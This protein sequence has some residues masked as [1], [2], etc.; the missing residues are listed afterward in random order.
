MS[1]DKLVSVILVLVFILSSSNVF[2]LSSFTESDDL[3]LDDDEPRY[4]LNSSPNAP[5]DPI[6]EDGETGLNVTPEL[7]V[8]VTHPDG[9]EMDV[10]FYDNVTDTEIGYVE[11]VPSGERAKIL[12]EDLQPAT[13]HLW[14]VVVYHGEDTTS[15]GPWIFSTGNV[16]FVRITDDIDGDELSGGTVPKNY[17]ETGYLSAYDDIHGFIGNFQGEW[18]ASGDAYLL[19][20]PYNTKNTIDVGEEAGDVWFNVTYTDGDDEYYH[21]IKYTVLIED[22][23]YIRITE[24]PGGEPLEDKTVL[25][26]T[27]IRGYASAYDEISGYLYTVDGDWSAEGADSRLLEGT[28]DES[29][30]IDVGSVGGT[31]W[32]NLSYEEHDHSVRLD[33]LHPTVDQI[34]ITDI[35]DGSP[36]IGGQVP[37]GFETWGN[38]S[39]YNETTGFIST[40]EVDWG[41]E[42][43]DGMDPS[44]GPTPSESSWLNVGHSGGDLTWVASYFRD[45][46]WYNDT[47]DLTVL[48]P[49]IDHIRVTKD[50]DEVTGGSVPV[51]HTEYFELSAYNHTTGFLNLVNG[52]WSSEG[53]NAYLLHGDSGTENGINVG[54]VPGHVWLNAS[55]EGLTH[56]VEYLVEDPQVDHVLMLENHEDPSSVMDDITVHAGYETTVYAAGFNHTTGFVELV[57]VEW[58]VDNQDGADAKVEP[59][60]GSW[61]TLFAGLSGGQIGL[62]AEYSS[63]VYHSIN[64]TVEPPVIDYIEIR[65]EGGERL[66]ELNIELEESIEMYAVG[67]N[68]TY[69]SQ[70]DINVDWNVAP[71]EIGSF[72]EEHGSNTVFTSQNIGIG[73]ITAV[74]DE[75]HYSF[76]IT[77]IDT[78]VPEIIGDIPDIE[79][80]K[81]FGLYEI[82]LS[83]YARD[84]YDPL[85][86]MQ[87]YLT[88]VDTA[89]I[90]TFGENQTGNHVITLL[91]KENVHGSML[92]TY[93]LVNS[94]GNKVSQQAWVNITDTYEAPAFRRCPDLYVH[95]DEA[96]VFDYTP[97]IIYDEEKKGDLELTTDDPE[98]T[99]VSGLRVTYEYPESML[100]EEIL[101]VI[102]IS[103]GIESDYTA[104][105]V[106]VTSNHPPRI[107]ERLPDVTIEQ[108]ETKE[109]VFNLDDYFMDPEGEQLF[110]SYGYTY[111]TITI[112]GDHRVD[113]RADWNWHGVERVTFR[114]KDPGN[115]IVEQTVNVTVIPVNYPPTIKELPRFVIRYEE[116][117]TFDLNY[118][119]SDKDNETHELT[120]TTCSPEYV[121]V[122]GTR[123]IMLYPYRMDELYG[124]YT[125][126]LEVFVSDGI[127]T[128]SEVTTVTVGDIYPPDLLIPLH[129]VAFYENE[130]LL[131]AFNLDNHFLD[132]Q[133]DT[134]Y[135]SSGNENIEVVIHENSS[136]DFYAPENWNGQELITIRA[137]NS[138]G[139]L[140]EDSLRVTVIPVNNPPVISDIPRQEGF[141]GRTWIL[142]MGDHISDVDN[143]TH[144]LTIF[145][146][147]PYVQVVRHKL[148]FEYDAPGTYYVTV[149]VSDGIDSTS[150]EI[151]VVVRDEET[152]LFSNNWIWMLIS[153]LPIAFVG[154]FLFFKIEEFTV[155]D[156]FLIHDSGVLIKHNARTLKAERDEDILAGMFLAVSN[157][158]EDAFGGEERDTLKR[159]EY[160]DNK[161]LVHKGKHVILAVFLSGGVPSWLLESMSNL[162]SDIEKRYEGAIEDWNGNLK[163][164]PG[165]GEMLNEILENKGRYSRGNWKR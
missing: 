26:D 102:T 113:I 6:P 116:P 70:E 158:V 1:Y 136:V 78:H 95:Y 110:M 144:E 75:L 60:D 128:T 27:N 104:I 98:Y 56:T 13:D 48:T 108:G 88:G 79:L 120:I 87:W 58:S 114:A 159:M 137:T 50:G 164:L 53:G 149:V 73:N 2:G 142:D 7:S 54:T 62:T 15:G 124:N 64:I 74:Y 23:D 86:D 156:I 147:D 49:T 101:V 45:G 151:E 150:T 96:Y 109:N 37:V 36:I 20:G 157:F 141:V 65:D 112:H 34:S 111:L 47:V 52:D 3:L 92:L 28:T 107:V 57:H 32:F 134:M 16:D 126:A 43:E 68:S 161:V 94:A 24:S 11:G 59:A 100:G 17:V 118:Y 10:Y 81:D 41:V 117:Y 21:G 165:I 155:D 85:S 89:L 9:L 4:G 25:P 153:L 67:S 103:D 8:Y 33:V 44:I 132:R 46:T 148:I 115:A 105:M 14:S 139:A 122:M 154:A 82:D 18:E 93:W 71:Q 51:D 127:D 99:T 143:E 135:Y 30:V 42:F 22:V 19:E 125:V 76:N 160:G 39:A 121:T 152:G 146:D 29:N 31:V 80:Q 69:G 133:D 63:S 91:S 138:A 55:Y 35:P 123:L 162:V 145:V 129:D 163:D 40:V 12:W 66:E 83:G 106:S 90:S 130:R 38:A 77:V 97:Y 72:F 5:S 140:M 131:N 119:I 61:T 84:E